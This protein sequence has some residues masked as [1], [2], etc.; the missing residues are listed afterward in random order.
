MT[1]SY[2][3]HITDQSIF[4]QAVYTSLSEPGVTIET[5]LHWNKHFIILCLTGTTGIR[6]GALE[7]ESTPPHY[8]GSAV[9]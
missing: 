3:N 9:G 6:A 7:N 2:L 4:L 5:I 1:S 8:S